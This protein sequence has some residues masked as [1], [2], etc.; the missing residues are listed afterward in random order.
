MTSCAGRYENIYSLQINF[1][2]ALELQSYKL[3]K[4]II[5]QSVV[6]VIKNKFFN[7]VPTKSALVLRTR[8]SKKNTLKATDLRLIY[9]SFH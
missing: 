1:Q 9:W 4:E 2:Q 8:F 5:S 3:N 6:I 7:F